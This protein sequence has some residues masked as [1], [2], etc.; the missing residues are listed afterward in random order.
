MVK[1]ADNYRYLSETHRDGRVVILSKN[2]DLKTAYK[3][4]SAGYRKARTAG[5]VHGDVY[6]FHGGK[7]YL[8]GG[9]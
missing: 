2:P 7:M 4:V 6:L 1:Q 5:F 9:R 8:I 3:I